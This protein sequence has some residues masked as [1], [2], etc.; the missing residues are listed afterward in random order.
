M[1]SYKEHHL[2]PDGKTGLQSSCQSMCLSRLMR[3]WDLKLCGLRSFKRVGAVT[4]KGQRRGSLSEVSFMSTY[5]FLRA[6][7]PQ[8]SLIAYM[9]LYL[10]STLFP[11]P[12]SFVLLTHA[13]YVWL[14]ILRNKVPFC[15]VY[16]ILTFFF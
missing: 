2:E 4:Q 12:G 6:G 11:C 14:E 3:K 15:S 5:R 10:I 16:Y 7:S 9:F 13:T 8:S 1:E